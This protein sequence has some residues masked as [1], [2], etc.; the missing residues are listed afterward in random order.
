MAPDT[1]QDIPK[2]LLAE[3]DT[4]FRT[5]LRKYIEGQ[6]TC[7]I[8][9]AGDGVDTLA[10]ILRDVPDLDL[11]LL[12]ISLPYVTG[13]QVLEII[14]SHP[15]LSNLPVIVCTA[16]DSKDEVVKILQLGV[17]DFILK[18]GNRATILGKVAAALRSK[19][20]SKTKS[21]QDP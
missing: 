4:D 11:V 19:G 3:D 16:H 2:I 21:S 5:L 10:L 12:D 13:L 18:P 9:E 20:Q 6:R 8:F 1:D 17:Y 14:S 15:H 7:T